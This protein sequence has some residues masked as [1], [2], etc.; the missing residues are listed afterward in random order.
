M[1]FFTQPKGSTIGVLK[2]GRT[3]QEALDEAYGGLSLQSATPTGLSDLFIKAAT[4]G[5]QAIV[6]SS[7]TLTEQLSVDLQGK[8][9]NILFLKPV[10][11][12]RQ[13]LVIRNAGPG[14]VIGG[15][16]V[17]GVRAI[18]ASTGFAA[19]AMAAGANP[20]LLQPGEFCVF[21]DGADIKILA[22]LPDGT[23]VTKS[24]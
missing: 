10:I 15:Q 17:K 14:S 7:V 5:R 4:T 21:S 22:K 1:D 8:V 6:N 2:D 19:V 16:L 13:H 3:V 23:E 11:S 9:V 18:G 20:S 12:D 24:L